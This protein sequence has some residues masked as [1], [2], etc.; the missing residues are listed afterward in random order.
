MDEKGILPECKVYL[1]S[2]LAIKATKIFGK[3]PKYLNIPTDKK[4]NPFLFKKLVATSTPQ[5]SRAITESKKPSI[6]IAG[7]GMCNGGRIKHHLK[8][9]L[10]D[11]K[12]SVIF[13]GYQTKGTLGRSII[14]GA[15]RVKIYGEKISV[16]AK[17][18]T[19]GGFSAHADRP[20]LVEYAKNVKNLKK[21]FL[22][23]GEPAKMETFK[24]QLNDIYNIQT[25]IV[26]ER[27]SVYLW[28]LKNN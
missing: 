16:K 21:I 15:K 10:W 20:T 19:I 28:K 11:H 1:D 17:I 14:E 3:F 9:N 4:S 5:E 18:Y 26:D 6:I 22:I 27:E 24:N 25:Q 2:P 23:H 7:S 8:H 12:N 13:V